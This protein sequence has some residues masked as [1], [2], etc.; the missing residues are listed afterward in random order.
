MSAPRIA[1]LGQINAPVLVF[2]GVYGNLEAL[3]ALLAHTRLLGIPS[4]R[5]VHTG[6]VAAYCADTRACAERLAD[7][8]IPAI[9]G[10]VEAQLAA[11][12]DDCGCGFDEGS[13]CDALSAQW[14]ARADAETTPHLRSWMAGLP[15]HLSFTLG[16]V[17]CHVVHG[18]FSDISRFMFASQSDAAFAGELASSDADCVIAGHTGI[19][20]TRTVGSRLWHNSGALGMPANDG[21]IRGWYALLTPSDTGIEIAIR[22]VSFDG[23]ATAR[24]IRAV[25]LP[26]DYARSLETGLWPN[27]E[28]LPPAETAASGDALAFEPFAWS[29]VR[30]AA[31]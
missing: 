11:S 30:A 16:G 22:P 8:G 3:D 17:R 20:F 19:P 4:G 28:H 12:A 14:Y 29:P 10:N 26:E 6:D 31:E 2:G 24:K 25:G 1:D 15:D 27:T 23:S 18:A 7:L 9:K 5:M 13:Q 21:T